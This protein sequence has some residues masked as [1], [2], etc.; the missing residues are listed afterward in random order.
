MGSVPINKTDA[1]ALVTWAQT[2]FP[3]MST[4][5]WLKNPPPSYVGDAV[6]V[7]GELDTLAAT[8]R[9]DSPSLTSQLDLDLALRNLTLRTRD[10]HNTAFDGKILGKFSFVTN[11][12]VVAVS[13]DGRSLPKIY[14]Y[15]MFLAIGSLLLT[16]L[17]QRISSRQELARTV[18]ATTVTRHPPF[19]VLV[20]KTLCNSCATT[21]P[22]TWMNSSLK[23]IR[24]GIIS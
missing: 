23:S 13:L 18:E 22:S 4:I 1:M 11:F 19:K 3:F 8:I 17:L 5:G 10:F 2:Y 15:G 9:S 14:S 24:H 12:S 7:L 21:L 20:A 6:D 16:K